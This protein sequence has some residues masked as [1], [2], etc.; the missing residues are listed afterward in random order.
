MRVR[1]QAVDADRGVRAIFRAGDRIQRRIDVAQPRGTRANLK[2]RQV[3]QPARFHVMRQLAGLGLQQRSRLGNRY[4]IRGGANFER[5]IHT[6]RGGHRQGNVRAIVRLET[7]GGYGQ[8]IIAGGKLRDRIVARA[9]TGTGINGP[10]FV[11]LHLD[12]SIGHNRAS[13]IGNGSLQRSSIG[14]A[15]RTSENTNSDSTARKRMGDTFS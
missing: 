5:H 2:H 15:D 9:G 14:L 6:Q 8:G 13:R 4:L 11:V 10:R 1:P 3:I 7:R 12:R